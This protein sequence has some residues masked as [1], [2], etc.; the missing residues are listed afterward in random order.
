MEPDM[1]ESGVIIKQTVKENFGMLMEI[2]TKENGRMIKQMDLV[3]TLTK[4]EQDMKVIGLTI[5]NMVLELKLG[6][7]EVNIRVNIMKV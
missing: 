2:F 1:K 6:E 4:M 5:Y 3:F 7:M